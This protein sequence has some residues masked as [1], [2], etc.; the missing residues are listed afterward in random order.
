MNLISASP[1]PSSRQRL[2]DL[3]LVVIPHR[4]GGDTAEDQRRKVEVALPDVVARL[5][6]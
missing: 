3:A 5:L 1:S 4:K 2:S 6:R